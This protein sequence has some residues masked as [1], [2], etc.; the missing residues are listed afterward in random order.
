MAPGNMS[1]IQTVPERYTWKAL[2]QGTTEN[3]LVGHFIHT[4][5]STDVKVQNINY[6]K[7]Y[8]MYHKLQL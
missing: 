1:I 6:G 7:Y 5:Q 8:C 2:H 3:N 4:W